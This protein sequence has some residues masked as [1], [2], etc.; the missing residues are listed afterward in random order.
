[1][2]DFFNKE[3]AENY[4]A[5][6]A[7][8]APISACMH[9]LIQ[10][11]LQDLPR[12]AR[13]LCVGAGTGAE[14]LSLAEVFPD[15]SFVGVDPSAPMLDVCRQR[16]QD[17]GLLGRCE[18]VHGYI[19]DAQEGAEFDAV[20]SVLV[21]HFVERNERAAFYQAIHDR[22]KPGGRMVSTE[23]CA[24]LDAP[25]IPAMLKDWERVQERMGAT[26]ESLLELPGMLRD[27]LTVMT[28]AATD[29]CIATAGLETPV[30]F[31]RAFMIRGVHARKPA[32]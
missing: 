15:W 14:I 19:E 20:L 17:A 24:D 18:L 30:E 7:G 4:D 12:D 6:N 29:A 32:A 1:M 3:M 31:F 25:E 22:L 11:S 28:P 26:R 23:I 21:A 13:V 8:L 9:F 27:A 2:S 5:R 16:L 10:L